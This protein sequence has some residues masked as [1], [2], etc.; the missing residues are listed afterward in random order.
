MV[1]PQ[2]PGKP[3]AHTLPTL[4]QSSLSL[5]PTQRLSPLHDHH[6]PAHNSSFTRGMVA[7]SGQPSPP[8]QNTSVPALPSLPPTAPSLLITILAHDYGGSPLP[9]ERSPGLPEPQ[10]AWL[11]VV[12][13]YFLT[14]SACPQLVLLTSCIL[15]PTPPRLPA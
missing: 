1:A 15:A 5:P 12:C 14:C 10:I 2:T 7:N 8:P 9:Q 11:P 3:S 6:S 13:P 4:S